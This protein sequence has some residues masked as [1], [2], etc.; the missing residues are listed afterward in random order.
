MPGSK[1]SSPADG[2]ARPADEPLG[3]T[4]HAMPMLDRSDAVA[5]Q[6]TRSG[7]WKMLAVLLVCMAPVVASYFSYYVL[8]PA[9]QSAFGALIDPQRP[10]PDLA[11]QTPDGQQANLTGLKGQWLLVSVAPAACNAVC[12]QNLYLQRQMRESLGKEKGR[13]D[14]VWLVL[15]DDAVPS[16][17]EN[18]L[19]E[20]T[21]LR[22][23]AERLS[24][25]LSPEAGAALSDHLY[26][27]DP[28]G[29]WMMR[30]PARL[31]VQGAG[32]AKRDL[33]RLLR[34]SNSWDRAG[35]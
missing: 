26:V 25:W 28:M 4:V 14:R 13:L 29:N 8:R 30:F 3:L 18:G 12:E 17:L 11:A 16:S 21:V 2:G 15:G 24:Q 27:V 22:V 20:A 5:V 35:R 7:R 19:R 33:E 31:D 6:R 9:G 34:A 1:S 32:K 23:D 10:L